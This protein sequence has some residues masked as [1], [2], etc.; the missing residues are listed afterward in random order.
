MKNKYLYP[1]IVIILVLA[2]FVLAV[3]PKVVAGAII[4]VAFLMFAIG[5]AFYEGKREDFKRDLRIHQNELRK[6]RGKPPSVRPEPSDEGGW[7]H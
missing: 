2:A 3:I 4:A 1:L 7:T 6:R 5:V